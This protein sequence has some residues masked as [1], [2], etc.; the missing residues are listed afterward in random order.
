MRLCCSL[1]SRLTED[2]VMRAMNELLHLRSHLHMRSTCFRGYG[3]HVHDMQVCSGQHS[4][5]CYAKSV[6]QVLKQASGF[7]VVSNGTGCVC[8]PD[9]Q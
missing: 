8:Q 2:G 7:P 9:A 6:L 4:C 5:S 1:W 3:E